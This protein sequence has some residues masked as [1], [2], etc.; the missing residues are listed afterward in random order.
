[1]RTHGHAG[2]TL[3]LIL[4]LPVVLVPRGPAVGQEGWPVRTHGD[5]APETWRLEGRWAVES[6]PNRPF[7]DL[8]V[9]GYGRV[10]ALAGRSEPVRVYDPDGRPVGTLGGGYDG[11]GLGDVRGMTRGPDDEVWTVERDRFVVFDTA[12]RLL[13]E[14][15]RTS[16]AGGRTWEGAGFDRRGRLYDKAYGPGGADNPVLLRLDRDGGARDTIQLPYLRPQAFSPGGARW[17]P[18]RPVRGDS[19]EETERPRFRA[20]AVAT[21]RYPFPHSASAIWAFD[22][23][24]FLWVARTDEYRVYRRTL[25]GDTLLAVER[26]A[27]R[28][29]VSPEEKLEIQR[30]MERRGEAPDTARIPSF[31]PV[32]EALFVDSDGRLWVRLAAD[33]GSPA[34]YDVYDGRGGYRARVETGVGLRRTEPT[35][36]GDDFYYAGA[37]PGRWP[38]PEAGDFAP[39]TNHLVRARLVKSDP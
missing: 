5:R 14:L 12:G 35:V 4:V 22:P 37:P 16:N 26:E 39:F 10:Y 11:A 25:E 31:K 38:L 21:V 30:R 17:I 34:V 28:R 1:M 24:G 2:A 6:P 20:A 29:P 19:T 9:D 8:L 33:P 7:A 23:R 36:R 15:P 13:R 3:G 27:T 32:L 18:G